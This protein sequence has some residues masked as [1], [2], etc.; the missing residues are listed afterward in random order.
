[1]LLFALQSAGAAY[2]VK[3]GD[4]LT[5]LAQRFKTTVA[6]LVKSN[7]IANPDRIFVGQVLQL[8]PGSAGDD[9]PAPAPPPGPAVAG[10]GGAPKPGPPPRP[11]PIVNGLVA[12]YP[13]GSA[14][15]VTV[16]PEKVL[17]AHPER[18]ALVPL[19]MASAKRAQ[20]PLSLLKAVAWQESN[21]QNDVLSSVNAQGIGQLMPDTV[22]FVNTLTGQHWDPRKP[23]DN[24]DLEASLL[25]F[26]I[27][28]TRGDLHTAIASYYQGLG[29]VRSHGLYDETKAYV[30][31]V[32]ALEARFR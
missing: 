31:D 15:L 17:A 20:V 27:Y 5:S 30:A 14:P 19:F 2:T 23:A 3:S 18:L 25:A 28:S 24:I 1:M 22:T 26:L 16:L 8:P 13:P 29:S 12:V 32:S 11:V 6:N 10:A 4:T 21:W 7:H 9:P